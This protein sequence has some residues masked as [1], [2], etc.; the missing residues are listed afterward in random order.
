MQKLMVA[1]MFGGLLTACNGQDSSNKDPDGMDLAISTILTDTTPELTEINVDVDSDD[2]E[3]DLNS[4]VNAT[5]SAD[6]TGNDYW[7][8]ATSNGYVA[9]YL[10]SSAGVDLDLYVDDSDVFGGYFESVGDTANELAIMEVEAGHLYSISISRYDGYYWNDEV[11][12]DADYRLVV[13]TPSR[14]ILGL[15]EN[16]YLAAV[17]DTELESDCDSYDYHP[18]FSGNGAGYDSYGIFDFLNAEYRDYND[19]AAHL[20]NVSN[21]G[22]TLAASGDELIDEDEIN[23]RYRWGMNVN[24]SL[25]EDLGAGTYSNIFTVE[26][27]AVPLVP[28]SDNYSCS[29][30]EQG[31]I[32]FLL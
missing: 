27:K 20:G 24:F 12:V 10:T 3:I 17:T 5:L 6:V 15:K 11:L 4:A 23:Y 13:A 14:K 18:Q 1:M 22:F 21:T 7:Y 28:E 25:A 2:V 8:T 9:I 30:T 19:N 16:E 26:K 31:T 29:G 32:K